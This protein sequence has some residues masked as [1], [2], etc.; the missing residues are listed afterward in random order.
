MRKKKKRVLFKTIPCRVP[1]NKGKQA[2]AFEL[3]APFRDAFSKITVRTDVELQGG[4]DLKQLTGMKPADLD[5]QLSARQ[6]QTAYTQVYEA[7]SSWQTHCQNEVRAMITGST[8]DSEMKAVLYR[9]NANKAWYK[10]DFEL[11]WHRTDDGELLVPTKEFKANTIIAIT[12]E[13][14][15]LCLR[16]IK[17]ARK[18]RSRPDLRHIRTI[19]M[20]AK[21]AQLQI[22]AN[23]FGYWL[24]L[25]TLTKGKPVLL[26]LKNNPFLTEQLK[27]GEL[28]N[29]VQLG[30][31]DDGSITIAPIV[32]QPKADIRTE[33]DV[34]GIDWG[35]SSLF[36]TS[37][38]RMFG[39][40]ML[41]CLRELDKELMVLQSDLQRENES[42]KK[43]AR[44]RALQSRISSYVKNEVGR[45][46]NKL[47]NE[48]IR[49]IV[50]EK[51]DFRFGGLSKR[52][53]RIVTRAGRKAVVLKL[54]R[55]SEEKGIEV[56]QV[57]AAYTSQQCSRCGHVEKKNRIDQKHFKCHCCGYK[58]NAD[59]N[60]ARNIKERRSLL[61]SLNSGSPTVR[62]SLKDKLLERHAQLCPTG[63]HL[64]AVR[65]IGLTD[66]RLST[67]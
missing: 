62:K 25:S 9:I 17:Q 43:N 24:N 60:A 50:V 26:P 3:L 22:G 27:S 2:K 15:K 44:Y 42:L 39:M 33:G 19:K 29:S 12:N 30:L 57:N 45:I 63:K 7:L 51:L 61:V 16:L 34:L 14:H 32:E 54:T 48:N 37:D 67:S 31:H 4:A 40:R 11:A 46:L 18:R 35:V 66:Y 28:L 47:S 41:S 36:T 21:I 65:N 52:I 1:A 38:G 6:I 8:L 64:S 5:S 49:E 59:V 10:P 58:C 20:D 53:N 55:L 23:S 56:T 13:Q